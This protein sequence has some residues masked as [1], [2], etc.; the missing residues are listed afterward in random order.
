MKNNL[1]LLILLA[2][3]YSCSH[4]SPTKIAFD[5]RKFELPI[6]VEKAKKLFGMMYMPYYG[7]LGH[8]TKEA[9]VIKAQLEGYPLFMGSDND[10]EEEYYDDYFVGISFMQPVEVYQNQAKAL[11][12]K[13]GK[14]F[15]DRKNY[16]YFQ[17]SNGLFVV[18][19]TTALQ[20][21][22]GKKYLAITFY[23]GISRNELDKYVE[24][25][26]I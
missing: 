17:T 26:Y 2:V 16:S 25:V 18:L 6:R 14:K 4:P 7:F 5:G 20:S 12:V 23:K 21:M 15:I 8:A 13:Y 10:S 22:P 9:P 3:F 24:H 1:I 11:E 19:K